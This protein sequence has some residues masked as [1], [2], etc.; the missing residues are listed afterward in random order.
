MLGCG[1]NSPKDASA[2]QGKFNLEVQALDASQQRIEA[3]ATVPDAALWATDGKENNALWEAALSIRLLDST[4]S[5]TNSNAKSTA[6]PVLGVYQQE[7][8]KLRFRPNF[9]LL[10]G[11]AYEIRFEPTVLFSDTTAKLT[12]LIKQHTVPVP[13]NLPVPR[14]EACYPTAQTLPANHLKFYLLFSEPMRRGNIFSQFTLLDQQ[15]QTVLE[16]FRETELWSDDGRRLTLWFHPGRQKTGVNLNV[17]IGPVLQPGNHY[18]LI[19]SGLWKSQA[20]VPLGTSYQKAFLAGP[21][22]HEQ[23]KLEQWQITPPTVT[24]TNALKIAFPEPFDWAL[25]KSRLW[26]ETSEGRNVE[27]SSLVG[28]EERSW[29]FTPKTPWQSGHYRVAVESLLE[30]LAGNSLARPFEVDINGEPV[31]PVASTLYLPFVISEP[32]R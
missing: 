26:I 27:G 24:D 10:P 23:P 5:R 25:L 30:D 2:Y 12:A 3:I 31:A 4:S 17:E 9:P 29:S 8:A 21:P 1:R 14:I 16:P 7:G 13:P 15:G 28:T 19:V 32:A 20:G 22:D 18:T 6:W 11:E